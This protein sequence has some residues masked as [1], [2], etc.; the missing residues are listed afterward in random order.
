MKSKFKLLC[1][2]VLLV[3]CEQSPVADDQPDNVRALSKSEKKLVQS[4]NEF[5][6]NLM[7]AISTADSSDNIF[8]S[9]LSVSMALGMT[10]NGAAGQTYEDMKATMALS[11]L[12]EDEINQSYRSLID[13]L[14]AVDEDVVFEIANS[15]WC[16]HDFG[17]E[18]DFINVNE[19]YFDAE[20]DTLDFTLPE[21]VEIINSWV[22]DN[23]HDKIQHVL[24]A[25][26]ADAVMYLINAVYFNAV[27][28]YEFDPEYTEEQL[29][30]L[31][32]GS[33]FTTDFMF[34]TAELNYYRTANFTMVELPY[35]I[36]NYAMTIILPD[37]TSDLKSFIQGLEADDWSDYLKKLEQK[38]G[39]VIFPKMK[40][41]YDLLLNNVL[42]ALGMGSAFSYS[43]DFSRINPYLD[44]YISRVIHKT[45]VEI[46]EEGTEAAAVTVVEEGYTSVG[47]DN[48]L[49]FALYLNRPFLFIIREK[50]TDTIVF[51]GEIG[52]PVWED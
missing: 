51:M 32:D 36:G 9:P 28:Q 31:P 14:T 16:R 44:L 11:G 26:P 7:Q 23:T 41:S 27:W 12:I 48:A 5:S 18:Q 29:F 20:V 52:A 10:M 50:E 39:T 49:D 47:P 35:G 45:F 19:T 21:A 40:F 24:D 33:S 46:D 15:I 38:E 43:A 6:F 8:I 37:N 22:A 30:Y 13:L 3:G 2:L 34:V 42:I 25:I 4:S 17:V 1:C